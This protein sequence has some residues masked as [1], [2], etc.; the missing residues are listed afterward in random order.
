MP[1]NRSTLRSFSVT[2]RKTMLIEN[3]YGSIGMAFI[4]G[5]CHDGMAGGEA[6]IIGVMDRAIFMNTKALKRE[7]AKVQPWPSMSSD[8][9]QWHRITQAQP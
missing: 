6:G 9:R 7:R 1:L 2:N 8:N 4:H 5:D 3:S